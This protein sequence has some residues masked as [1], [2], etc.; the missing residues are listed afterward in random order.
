[1]LENVLLRVWKLDESFRIAQN[2]I[3]VQRLSLH[4]LVLKGVFFHFAFTL[5]WGKITHRDIA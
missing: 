5:V 3:R 1:M 4:L 2:S